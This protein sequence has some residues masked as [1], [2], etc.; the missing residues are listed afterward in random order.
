[1]SLLLFGFFVSSLRLFCSFLVWVLAL[2]YA[3][4]HCWV[5]ILIT[6]RRNEA[7]ILFIDDTLLERFSR[8][9]VGRWFAFHER[10]RI[11]L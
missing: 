3:F 10:E 11:V 2:L 8:V 6:A 1:M 4:Q 5:F 7:Y 9:F